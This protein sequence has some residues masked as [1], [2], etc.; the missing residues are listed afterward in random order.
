MEVTS[1]GVG[2]ESMPSEG[3]GEDS[4]AAP[5][6]VPQEEGRHSADERLVKALSGMHRHH[7]NPYSSF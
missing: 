5:V 2:L 1:T 6:L 3:A 7:L 4:L